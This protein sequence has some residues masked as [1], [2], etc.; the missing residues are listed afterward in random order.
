MIS[1]LMIS[2]GSIC[3]PL[4]FF[5][6]FLSPGRVTATGPRTIVEF[7][8]SNGFSAINWLSIAQRLKLG[9]VEGWCF[10]RKCN[11]VSLRFRL[12]IKCWETF[13]LESMRHIFL[14]FR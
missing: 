10:Q 11:M 1:T 6:D 14:E 12:G 3:R 9:V 8:T 7:G 2:D 5:N 4:C 13:F